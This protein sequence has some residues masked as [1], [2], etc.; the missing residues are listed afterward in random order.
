MT[1]KGKNN[2]MNERKK[3][4]GISTGTATETKAPHHIGEELSLSKP[5][6]KNIDK[7]IKILKQRGLTFDDEKK[8]KKYLL[9][10]NYYN[11]INGYSK[12]FQKSPDSDE[13]RENAQ[14][15]EVCNLYFF[16]K[17]IKQLLLNAILTAEHHLKSILAYRF[18]EKYPDKRYAYLDINC[19]D[20][21]QTLCVIKTISKITKIINTHVAIGKKHR[22]KVKNDIKNRKEKDIKV[23]NNSIFYYV[24]KYDDVPIWVIV[25]YLNLGDLYYIIYCLPTNLQNKIAFDLCGFISEN[26]PDFNEP[27]QPEKM[28]SFIRNIKET[29]NICAHNNRLLDFYCNASSKYFKPLHSKYEKGCNINRKS[30]YSTFLSLQ[31]FLSQTEY[32]I[33]H[34]SIRKRTRNLKNKLTSITIDEIMQLLGFPDNWYEGKKLEQKH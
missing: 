22:G 33:L 24:E 27:F 18:A 25:D 34:N 20:S 8:A 7:Q 28:L 19:Y 32:N 13:Y 2:K 29:R 16:D 12:Y 11:I 5:H 10:N 4:G 3:S 30:V 1:I 21:K 17:E 14:F 9:S 31:C 15:D 23:G 6:F 26:I